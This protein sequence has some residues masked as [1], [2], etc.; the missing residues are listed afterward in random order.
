MSVE[1]VHATRSHTIRE[2]VDLAVRHVIFTSI[3]CLCGAEMVATE[4]RDTRPHR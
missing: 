2:E 3:V 4:A 1:G